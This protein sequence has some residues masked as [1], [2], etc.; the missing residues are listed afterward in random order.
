MMRSSAGRET[1]MHMTRRQALT[2]AAIICGTAATG[3]WVPGAAAQ[4]VKAI[5]LQ[6]Y[7]VR[8]AF[9]KDPV[10]TLER[11]ARI[12]YREIEYGGGGYDKLDPAMLRR[13]QDRLGL[14]APSIHVPYEEMLAAPD[15]VI[16][17]ART[18]GT[19]LLVIPYAAE[20]LRAPEPWRKL[21]ADLNRFGERARGA[22]MQLAYHNH[23]FEFTIRHGDKSLFD[24]LTAGT[25]RALVKIELDLFWTIAAG[26]DP[27]A[28][29]DRLA[30]GII[31]YHVKDRTRDG[32]MVS[33]GAGAI[34]FAAIF[35]RNA[36][37]GV[38]HLFVENDFAAQP[39]RPDAFSSV[40]FS[41]ASLKRLVG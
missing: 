10:A 21:V 13:T 19:K 27:L 22:G 29:I 40:E 18:L 41:F 17:R 34:D 7:T 14:A 11:V 2:T 16:A 25:D 20:A 5:G 35:A 37:A 8:D 1:A 12:G 28:W 23:D 32:T 39:Y 6:L 15:A 26:E 38:R 30:G 3:D 4:Q 31:A 9:Q 33:V 36:E 24:Q